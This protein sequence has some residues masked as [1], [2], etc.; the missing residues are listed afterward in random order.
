MILVAAAALTC[1]AAPASAQDGPPPKSGW[2]RLFFDDTDG[3]FDFSDFLARGGFIP[4]PII[5]TEPAVGGGG[6]VAAAFLTLPNAPGR[7]PGIDVAAG[8]RT[9]NGSHFA[10]YFQS[11]DA[12]GGQVSYR[13]GIGTGEITLEAHPRGL[14]AGLE[15]TTAFDYGLIGG[16]RVHL[17]DRRFSIGPSLDFRS[18]TRTSTS[19]T[20]T[21]RC[22]PTSIRT[23]A[24]ARLA[25]AS[26]STAATTP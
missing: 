20:S 3:A 1:P 22:G 16:V 23:C 15:Y 13:F 25:S 4:P 17:P 11:G 5:I 24:P 14:P 2:T 6:G 9:G 8:V 7:A 10:G 26:I 19:A 21:R 18:L 12:M